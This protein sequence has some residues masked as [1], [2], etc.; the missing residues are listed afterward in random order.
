MKCSLYL[1]A[2][3]VLL[4]GSTG[5]FAQGGK[6]VDTQGQ[7]IT[8][9]GSNK[10]PANNGSKQDEGTRGSGIN[11]GKGKTHERAMIPNPYRLTARRDVIIKAVAE[12][13]R[14][15]K[16]ILD[17]GSSKSDDGIL[18]TQPYTFIKGAVV[19][20]PELNRY[21][22]I[23]TTDTRNWTRGRYTITVEVQPIDGM[24]ANVSVNAKI[25]GRIDGATGAEWI[26]LP[27]SGEAEQEFL[28][29]L[30]QNVTGASPSTSNNNRVRDINIKGSI[31]VADT[32][33]KRVSVDATPN[34]V[35]INANPK[36][37]RN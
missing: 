23:V 20:G 37:T 27:S 13:M 31:V 1:L 29:A 9:N 21:A 6:G 34:S 5:V 16:L 22:S 18:V 36:S 10:A 35:I 3:I 17:E 32:G 26:S 28:D 15:R 2:P 7:R 12:V 24:S 14:D 33:T 19:T 11:F 4:A 25:E 30:I 8:D